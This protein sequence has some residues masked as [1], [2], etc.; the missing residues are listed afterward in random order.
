VQSDALLQ[1]AAAAAASRKRL[2][3]ARKKLLQARAFVITDL[4]RA[5]VERVHGFACHGAVETTPWPR[6][7]SC[8]Q[9]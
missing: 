5:R 3:D 8:T 9:R 1:R 6:T 7:P 4:Q 2:R